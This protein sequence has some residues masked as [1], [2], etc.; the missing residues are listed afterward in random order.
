MRGRG[1]AVSFRLPP[2]LIRALDVASGGED[3]SVLVRTLLVDGLRHLAKGGS[4]SDPRKLRI[5]EEERR[6]RIA[7]LI[8]PDLPLEQEQENEQ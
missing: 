2:D 8:A 3:R 1:R 5:T 6:R 4:V 7:D